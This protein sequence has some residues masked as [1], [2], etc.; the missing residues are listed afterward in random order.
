MSALLRSA[1]RAPKIGDA[2][3]WALPLQGPHEL[4]QVPFAAP[5]TNAAS[6]FAYHDKR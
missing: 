3:A 2:A 1:A 5:R 6:S 4:A